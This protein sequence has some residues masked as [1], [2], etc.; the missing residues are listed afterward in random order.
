MF[1]RK[2]KM[3]LKQL[4]MLFFVGFWGFL[5]DAIVFP[6]FR[7]FPVQKRNLPDFSGL[8]LGFPGFSVGKGS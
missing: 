5:R 6:F 2:H 7:T 3:L 4:L 1:L 8:F